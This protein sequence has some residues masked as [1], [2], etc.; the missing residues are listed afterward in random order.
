MDIQMPDIDGYTATRQIRNFGYSNL[1]VVACSAHAF[2]TDVSRSLSEG[3]DDHISKPVEM[4]ALATLLQRI[5]KE[6]DRGQGNSA[7]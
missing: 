7:A 3:M 5:A 2:D 1:K 4:S 6:L